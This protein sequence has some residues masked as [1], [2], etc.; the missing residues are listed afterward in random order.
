VQVATV[1]AD[2]KVRFQKVTIYRDFGT[3]AELR[4]GLQGGESLILSPPADLA[5]GGKVQVANPLP[6][7]DA[8]RRT[9][10]R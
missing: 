6:A 1:D 4:D 8:G 2:S 9:A 5:E 3:T 7:P 10:L